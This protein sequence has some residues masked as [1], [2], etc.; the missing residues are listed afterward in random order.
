MEPNSNKAIQN[1]ESEFA[2]Y[3]DYFE[4]KTKYGEAKVE[5]KMLHEIIETKDNMY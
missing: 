2:F 3:E 5:Y 1:M 4:E